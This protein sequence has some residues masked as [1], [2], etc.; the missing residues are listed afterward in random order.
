MMVPS[1]S[2]FSGRNHGLLV[3]GVKVL[4]GSTLLATCGS[5]SSAAHGFT[6][7]LSCQRR[8]PHIRHPSSCTLQLVRGRRSGHSTEGWRGSGSRTSTIHT[9]EF[10]LLVR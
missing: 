4:A 1:A 9:S 8:G 5:D 7:T 3:G 10:S 6:V 2:W